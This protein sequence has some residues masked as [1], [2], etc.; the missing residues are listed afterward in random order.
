MYRETVAA[1]VRVPVGTFSML[2][3]CFKLPVTPGPAISSVWSVRTG[4]RPGRT[5]K[6]PT[7]QGLFKDDGA[8]LY[9]AGAV[10]LYEEVAA[11]GLVPQ[12]KLTGPSTMDMT[13]LPPNAAEVCILAMLKRIRLR[14]AAGEGRHGMSPG[15]ETRKQKLS[16]DGE[17]SYYEE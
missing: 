7:E 3:G 9:S 12:I 8:G 5:P 16:K 2:L 11:K 15:V 17:P 4:P 14:K 1:G 13:Y 10:A 6:Q